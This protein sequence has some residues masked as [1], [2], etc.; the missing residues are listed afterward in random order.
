MNGVSI[1][2]II[3]CQNLG[4]Y[5]CNEKVQIIKEE[6]CAILRN[7]WLFLFFLVGKS[8]NQIPLSG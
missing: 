1:F 2:C 5:N 3:A 4:K 8:S 7:L 6:I